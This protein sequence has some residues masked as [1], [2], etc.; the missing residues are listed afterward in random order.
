[1]ENAFRLFVPL[2]SF[3]YPVRALLPLLSLLHPLR[4]FHTNLTC[5]VWWNDK[6]SDHVQIKYQGGGFSG[7][8][9]QLCKF[10]FM[11]NPDFQ[12]NFRVGINNTSDQ[13]E[14]KYL[15]VY[16]GPEFE[17]FVL[18]PEQ[19]YTGTLNV[20][21]ELKITSQGVFID[22]ELSAHI[23][24]MSYPDIQGNFVSA[25]QKTFWFSRKLFVRFDAG[26]WWLGGGRGGVKCYF[27]FTSDCV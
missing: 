10:V 20:L 11:S 1:M 14:I 22:S 24:F 27:R 8:L 3:L 26:G 23:S 2:L 9:S 6:T 17:S 18:K 15:W 12:G 7:V 13:A 16:G 4:L 21:I 25:R 5:F 19:F